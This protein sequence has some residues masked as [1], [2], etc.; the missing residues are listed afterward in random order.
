MIWRILDCTL[1]GAARYADWHRALNKRMVGQE[2]ALADAMRRIS[3]D[4]TVR[5]GPFQGMRYPGLKSVYSPL[6][7][8]LLGSYEC[9]I[10]PC[11]ERL[12]RE[13]YTEIVNI[14]CAEGYYAV[15]FAMR[16]PK[17]RV[18]A[19]DISKTARRLCAEMARLNAVGDRV[20]VG[21]ICDGKT[22][23]SIPFTGRGL[24]FC[25]CE[26]YETELLTSDT[27]A[28]LRNCDLVVEVHDFINAGI[29]GQ[30]R[31]VFADS[32]DISV[33]ESMDDMMK[34]RVFQAPEL[35]GYEFQVRKE[36]LSEWRPCIMEWFLMTPKRSTSAELP[37]SG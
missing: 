15:G 18:Y 22:L 24:V 3:S 30:I 20:S 28:C 36:L 34:S 26:G 29:S 25:D 8:K 14:G 6:Y 9:E 33:T 7:P 13:R 19:F 27:V 21:R 31:R 10:A 5:R 32:H 16:D 37:Q 4:L 17:A 1:L 12:C 23:R 11:V 35:D 2:T